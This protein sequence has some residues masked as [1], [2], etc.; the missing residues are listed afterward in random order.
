MS[1]I[2]FIQKYITMYVNL[3]DGL[4]PQYTNVKLFKQV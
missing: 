1:V 2:V 3:W 4:S